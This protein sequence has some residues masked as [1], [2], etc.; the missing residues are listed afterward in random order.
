MSAPCHGQTQFPLYSRNKQSKSLC[1]RGIMFLLQRIIG[2]LLMAVSN[3]EF[4]YL[5]LKLLCFL[6]YKLN[7][8]AILDFFFSR[9]QF[10]SLISI[11]IDCME[12]IV[13][14]LNA[15]R[16]VKT[17]NEL[18]YPRLIKITFRKCDLRRAQNKF[19]LICGRCL[20]I[21]K[22]YIWQGTLETRPIHL[23]IKIFI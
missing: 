21:I 22:K 23:H 3:G 12:Q 18:I 4:S 8:S 14:T 1:F 13:S 20:S 5:Y 16:I 10:I 19:L 9:K 6:R 2:A 15:N 17:S 7:E 11:I